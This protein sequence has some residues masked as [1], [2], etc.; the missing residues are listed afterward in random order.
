VVELETQQRIQ[1]EREEQLRVRTEIRE[2]S[3]DSGAGRAYS[4]LLER[5]QQQVADFQRQAQKER[6]RMAREMRERDALYLADAQRKQKAINQLTEALSAT[7]SR[8]RTASP[9][10]ASG[11]A[12]P[13][14]LG[15]GDAPGTERGEPTSRPKK[16]VTMYPAS[17]HTD[18][19]SDKGRTAA[20]P[21]WR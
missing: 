14:P 5:V 6:E 3:R 16:E 19:P 15:G 10:V 1:S 21:S 7:L 13:P 20:S 17:S 8:L 4:T 12:P 2:R 18:R 11:A 9:A